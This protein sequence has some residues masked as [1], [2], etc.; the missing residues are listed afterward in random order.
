M[1]E[2]RGVAEE[3]GQQGSAR[4]VLTT[5]PLQLDD[6]GSG[7]RVGPGK[8]PDLVGSLDDPHHLR[9]NVRGQVAQDGLL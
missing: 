3:A 4:R 6:G 1:Q 5:V 7:S 2:C 8:V 9:A